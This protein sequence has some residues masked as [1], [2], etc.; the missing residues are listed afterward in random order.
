[1]TK[2]IGSKLHNKSVGSVLRHYSLHYILEKLIK[3]IITYS[4]FQGN[5]ERIVFPLEL[6]NFIDITGAREK[7]ISILM[8]R[9]SHDPV[10]KEKRFFDPI[11]MVNINIKVEDSWVHLKEFKDADND[12]VH[13]AKTTGL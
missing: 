2:T 10:R 11:A 6:A 12:V 7:I 8:K 1:M 9:N 4:R 3:L 5:I 13:I